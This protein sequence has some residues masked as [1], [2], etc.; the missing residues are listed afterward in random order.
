MNSRRIFHR[1]AYFILLLTLAA[2]LPISVYASSVI[3]FLLLLNWITEGRFREK[4]GRIIHSRAFLVYSLFF[5]VHLLAMTWSTDLEYGLKDLKIKLPILFIPLLVVS[6][7]PLQMKDTRHI[8]AAFIAGNVIGSFSSVLAL[9]ELIPVELEGY[10]NAS[11]FINHIRFSLMVVLSILFAGYLFF[12][13]EE[14]EP[15]SIRLFYLFAIIWLTVFLL[16]LRSLSGIFILALIIL[17]LAFRYL[18][19]VRQP[20]IRILFS[21]VIVLLP[22][23]AILYTVYAVNRFYDV[24]ELDT[25]ELETF[26]AEGNA[27]IHHTDNKEI[28]NGHYV[29]IYLCPEE[30]RREWNTRSDYPYMGKTENGDMIRF[31]LIRY[32]ASK[33][34]RKDASGVQQLTNEDVEAIEQGIANHI[35]LN[36]FALYPRIYE[37]IWEFDRY[38][39]GYSPNDKS[40]VQRYYYLKAGVHIAADNLLYGVGTGDVR[41]AFQ[42]YYEETNSPLRHE[43]RRRAHN[44][45]LT[46]AIAFGIPGLIV[47]LF[48]LVYP[49]TVGKR[50]HAYLVLVFLLTMALSMLDEDTLENTS[51]AVMFGLFYGVLIFGGTLHPSGK[52]QE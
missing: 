34:L 36:R 52:M 44:Q 6:S 50:I 43:R 38:R 39:L 40:L 12:R 25:A 51:G 22:L 5:L 45:F 35:Y 49:A 37:L 14:G 18:Q 16:V 21:S 2:V 26:T 30:L 31:T 8:L 47:C 28:E 7:E 17:I 15:R 33:G 41:K 23:L 42:D 11:L 29:W 27:Y 20:G 4:W 32:L 46:F 24:E 48:A 9:L 13:K 3:Q 1:K 10:R 19:T